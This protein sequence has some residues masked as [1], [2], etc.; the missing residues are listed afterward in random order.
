MTSN[1]NVQQLNL[2]D[3]L[4]ERHR[5]IRETV[6]KRWN[7]KNDIH[8]SSSEWYILT[9]IYKQRPT[10]SYITKN[11][12]IT[13]QAIHKVIK[14]LS[15]KGLVAVQQMENNKKEK[16]IELTAYGEKCYETN[17]A[18]KAKIEDEI[19]E[20]LGAEQV[21]MLKNLLRLDWGTKHAVS[22]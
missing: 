12:D 17:V 15:E 11:V 18:L 9:K 4:H 6:E 3:L 20:K 21:T 10:I 2:I 16:C 19:E 1:T 22:D 14:N 5:M 13:R 8:I 7:E